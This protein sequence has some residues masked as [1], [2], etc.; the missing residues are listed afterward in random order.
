MRVLAAACAFALLAACQKPAETSRLAGNAGQAAEVAGATVAA[1]AARPLSKNAALKLMHD[2]HENMEK[3]GKSVKAARQAMTASPADMGALRQSA[4]TIA[5]FA[6]KV[7]SWFPAGTGPNVGKT[8]AKAE[9]WQKPKDFSARTLDFRKAADAFEAAARSGDL[10]R[11]KD[12]FA[13]LGKTC[14]ACHDPYRHE[15]E[16]H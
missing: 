6:P 10:T 4:G 11:I 12:S 15:H 14:K 8:M 7:A 5:A 9:I 16:K 2:R 1:A 13:A 3:I